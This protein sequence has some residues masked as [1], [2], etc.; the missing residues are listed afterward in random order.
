MK[1]RLFRPILVA[2]PVVTFAAFATFATFEQG[3][4]AADD[5][6][7]VD[8]PSVVSPDDAAT[9]ARIDAA[10]ADLPEREAQVLRA[11]RDRLDRL[12][13]QAHTFGS[14]SH[15]FSGPECL[16]PDTLPEVYDGA[17][18]V[19]AMASLLADV[20]HQDF[21]V[22]TPALK[23]TLV[24]AQAQIA[25]DVLLSPHAWTDE[26]LGAPYRTDLAAEAPIEWSRPWIKAAATSGL[27]ICLSADDAL[28]EVIQASAAHRLAGW[29]ELDDDARSAVVASLLN[30]LSDLY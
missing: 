19:A 5:T 1:S 11:Q 12:R 3:A 30:G 9:A 24:A 26:D 18:E 7:P 14:A 20:A 25:A 27:G 23:D 2:L 17:R 6:P 10:I 28:Y 4:L 22:L 29:A 15:G 13:S 16:D 21:P 8:S